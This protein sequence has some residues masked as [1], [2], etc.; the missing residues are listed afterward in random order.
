MNQ[1]YLLCVW[2]RAEIETALFQQNN[3]QTCYFYVRYYKKNRCDLPIKKS[4]IVLKLCEKIQK[5]S[6]GCHLRSI[7]FGGSQVFI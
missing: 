6:A 5:K 3:I 7:F 1:V 2:K 4:F